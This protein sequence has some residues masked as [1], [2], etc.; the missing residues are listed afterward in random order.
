MEKN[1]VSLTI[2]GR[3]YSVLSEEPESHL[4]RVSVY[5]D[6][7]ISEVV[8]AFP[9]ISTTDAAVMAALTIADELIRLRD[10]SE[11]L[12]AKISS[13]FGGSDALPKRPGEAYA[14]GA[15]AVLQAPMKP[16]VKKDVF[17]PP[18]TKR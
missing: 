10:E 13:A 6:Q 8:S 16:N 3:E 5:V 2:D 15:D 1:R 17:I 4:Y 9:R 18:K 11:R 14:S 12:D 7:K